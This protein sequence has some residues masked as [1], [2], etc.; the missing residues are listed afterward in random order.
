MTSIGQLPASSRSNTRSD[1]SRVGGGGRAVHRNLEV[2]ASIRSV[3]ERSSERERRDGECCGDREQGATASTRGAARRA[4]RACSGGGPAATSS[5]CTRSSRARSPGSRSD[6]TSSSKSGAHRSSS[7][8]ASARRASALR[9][10]VFTVPSGIPRRSATSLC[11]RP[12][13][14]ASSMTGR[15]CSGS[16]SS[17]RWTRQAV[18]ARLGLVRRIRLA[19][20]AV[21]ELG[22][23]LGRAPESVRDR[24]SRDGVEPR[25]AAAARRVVRAGGAPDRDE[26]V[27]GRVLRT[28][29]VAE[30]AERE[31]EHRARVAAVQ[32]V[33]RAAVAARRCGR[34]AG[35]RSGARAPRRRMILGWSRNDRPDRERRC[36][37]VIATRSRPGGLTGTIRAP[38]RTSRAT[39]SQSTTFHHASR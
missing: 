27:L 24:V 35:R 8:S 29:A 19:P 33:E 34:S 6:P 20:G 37:V 23:G 2:H 22:D 12:L 4:L 11:D 1:A 26:G 13:Q 16:T 14:Y 7:S 9:V 3:D 36:H 15:S 18:Q 10:R 28:A 38:R 5:S 30:T 17:A 31:P 25:R 39:A 21:L 32:L